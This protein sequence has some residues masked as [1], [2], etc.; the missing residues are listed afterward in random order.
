MA[1]AMEKSIV[2]MYTSQGLNKE[3][4]SVFMGHNYRNNTM[5]SNLQELKNG[6]YIYI[7]DSDGKRVRYK[8]YSVYNSTDT[9]NEYITRNVIGKSEISLVTITN[10]RKEKTIVLAS[11]YKEN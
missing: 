11:E 7:T 10:D 8:V 2:L 4:N 3:G 9:E 6:E 5:F 1:E